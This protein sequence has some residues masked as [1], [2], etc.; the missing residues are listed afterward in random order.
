M[1]GAEP[2]FGKVHVVRA[3]FALSNGPV[4][5]KT[6]VKILGV[7]E[8]SVRTI[9]KKLSQDDL[10]D[11]EKVGH[12]LSASG[13]RRVDSILRKMSLPKKVELSELL[14]IPAQSA[15]VVYNAADRMMSAV[16]L[17]DIALKAGAD[18][19]LILARKNGKLTYPG[20]SMKKMVPKPIE[21]NCKDGDIVVI[22]FAKTMENA[23]DGAIS[24]ALEL[25]GI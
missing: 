23:E 20:D 18:G 25:A 24:V 6:L 10:I 9:L 2:S 4:G 13:K 15:V 22:G 1:A 21:V 14:G 5:R 17:R 12:T 8:G 16:A 7:G 19:A 11:S 3:L